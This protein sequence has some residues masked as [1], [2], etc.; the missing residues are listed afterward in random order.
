MICG[1]SS[2]ESNSRCASAKTS[3]TVP[4]RNTSPSLSTRMESA[5]FAMSSML[6]EMMSIVLCRCFW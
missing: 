1:R 2:E 3:S 4:K 5:Y 6:C